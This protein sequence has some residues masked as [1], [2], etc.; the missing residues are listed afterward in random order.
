MQEFEP[1]QYLELAQRLVG[2]SDNPA[3]LRSAI[4]RAYYGALL[5]ARPVAA[6]LGISSSSTHESFWIDLGRK[7][8]TLGEYG[9]SLRIWR[10]H[11]DYDPDI[12]IDGWRAQS[13]VRRA[14]QIFE[15]LDRSS[16]AIPPVL[17]VKNAPVTRPGNRARFPQLST[18]R[19]M[20]GHPE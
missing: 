9:T 7:L 6:T 5:A 20:P 1:R 11:A 18:D 14:E 2:E 13:C 3:A 12:R 10:N 4:S 8:K 17:A 16:E 19:P 15:L